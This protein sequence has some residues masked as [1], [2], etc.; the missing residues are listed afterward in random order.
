VSRPETER[1]HEAQSFPSEPRARAA[2]ADPAEDA[3][4]AWMCRFQ[5]GDEGA[6]DLIVSH[7]QNSVYHFILGSLKDTG[8]AED[9]TQEVF[10]RA[11][12]SRERYR[13]TARL[14]TWLFTIA[15]R[16]VLNEIRS[17]RRRRRVFADG[18]PTRAGEGDG[19]GA[20][21]FWGSVPDE[22][23]ESPRDTAERH[24]L[25]DVLGRLISALPGN[26]QAALRLHRSEHFS[27]AEIGEVLGVS[28]LAVKS[29]LVRAREKLRVGLESYSSG[30]PQAP[31]NPDPRN[32]Q[33]GQR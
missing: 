12:R 4:V 20:E 19:T 31:T 30:R 5:S 11:Y 8:R 32:E 15:N 27:Y 29:L 1:M 10:V 16:L 33:G 6:F 7:Y 17:L 9:L 13:P 28:A 24:E 23:S 22:R 14:K 18:A 21:A 3:G 25:E 26:Q 2:P